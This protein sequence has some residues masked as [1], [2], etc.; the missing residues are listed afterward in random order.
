MSGDDGDRNDSAR[1]PRLFTYHVLEAVIELT[2]RTRWSSE[3]IRAAGRN[4]DILSRCRFEFQI[5][6]VVTC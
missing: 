1:I 5:M 6:V 2:V 3:L 4:A